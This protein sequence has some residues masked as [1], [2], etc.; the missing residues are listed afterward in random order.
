M[1]NTSEFTRED[2]E[3]LLDA[4]AERL[5]DRGIAAS[6]YVVGGAAIALRGISADRRTGDVD[7]LMVPEAEVLQ[8]AHEVA[9]DRQIRPNWLNSAARPYIPPLPTEARKI[10]TDPGLA[11]QVASDEHLLAMKIIAARGRR[12]MGDIVSLAQRLQLSA[13]S[14][15]VALAREAYGDDAI[16]H[17]HGGHEDL[18][19]HCEAIERALINES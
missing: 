8:A 11:L 1:T 5:R 2:I 19:L 15:L 10:P 13:A 16:E 12:D 3:S 18:Q 4:V 7:A 14:D 17:V 9:S 6:V